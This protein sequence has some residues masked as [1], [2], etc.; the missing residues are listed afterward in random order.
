MSIYLF[1]TGSVMYMMKN[2]LE[3][4]V[5]SFIFLLPIV[6]LSLVA[7]KLDSDRLKSTALKGLINE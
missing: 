2:S 3:K 7:K 4:H 6:L 5:L 1:A